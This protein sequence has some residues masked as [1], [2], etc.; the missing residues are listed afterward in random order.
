[1]PG[2]GRWVGLPLGGSEVFFL[3]FFF[4][5]AVIMVELVSVVM[6]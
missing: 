1:M 6:K 3:Q 2:V 5:C 4:S